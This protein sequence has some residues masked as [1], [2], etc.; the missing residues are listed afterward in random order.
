MVLVFVQVW[1]T[2]KLK[3]G[4][5]AL[6]R[7]LFDEAVGAGLDYSFSTPVT[8]VC[9]SGSSVTVTTTSGST[10]RAKRLISTIPLNVL[11][12]ISFSPPLSATRQ[13]AISIGQ[14]NQM[15]KIHAE[16][17]GDGMTSWGGCRYPSRLLYGYGVG[18]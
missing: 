8:A 18:G 13:E 15:N 1:T 16:V 3:K 12:T 6:A 5:S 10:F 7:A 9:D 17:E 14:V 4:Q 11:H 2:Y